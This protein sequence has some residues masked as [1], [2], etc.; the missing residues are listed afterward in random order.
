MPN[1]DG[2]EATRAI[3]NLEHEGRVVGRETPIVAM[4]AFSMV[5]A[6]SAVVDSGWE[7]GADCVD[8][9]LLVCLSHPC[10]IL[11]RP[12]SITPCQPP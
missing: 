6:T 8:L 9:S 1:V 4:T 2:F 10:D 3:R 7:R 12:F 11:F 5:G